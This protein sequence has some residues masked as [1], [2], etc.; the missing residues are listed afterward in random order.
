[1][2]IEIGSPICCSPKKCVLGKQSTGT[3]TNV[4]IDMRCPPATKAVG[5]YHTHP[6]GQSVL[7]TLDIVNLQK[8]GLPVGCVKGKQG[9][10]CYRVPL[11]KR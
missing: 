5:T 3:R 2:E 6:G 7:S 10:K 8:A 9:L 11:D 1:M 4:R